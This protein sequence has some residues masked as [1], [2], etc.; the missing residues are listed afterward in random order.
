MRRLLLDRY[1]GNQ[2]CRNDPRPANLLRLADDYNFV[3]AID[4]ASMGGGPDLW[5]WHVAEADIVRALGR[6]WLQGLTHWIDPAQNLERQ[7]DCFLAEI[8]NVQPDFLLYDIEQYDGDW[9]ISFKLIPPAKIYDATVFIIEYVSSMCLLPW[10]PYSAKWF[11]GR[12]CPQLVDWF[13]DHP[14]LVASYADYGQ[15]VRRVTRAAFLAWVEQVAVMPMP[16]S[17]VGVLRNPVV[18]Q[19]SSTQQLACCPANYDASI[20]LDDPGFD[21]WLAGGL[22]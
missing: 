15:K 3:G 12:Y 11:L 6:T 20:I 17:G 1:S 4:K 9:G 14:A 8:D 10:M 19:V 13:G 2:P 16:T 7:A 22:Q 21:A 18:R 5:Q